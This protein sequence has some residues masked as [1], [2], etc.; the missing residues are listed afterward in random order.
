LDAVVRFGCT[1]FVAAISQGS[2]KPSLVGFCSYSSR[3]NRFSC[4]FALTSKHA[5]ARRGRGAEFPELP[6][7]GNSAPRA[8]ERAAR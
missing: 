7:A 1:L 6:E 5:T 8:L 4:P 2:V 3:Y